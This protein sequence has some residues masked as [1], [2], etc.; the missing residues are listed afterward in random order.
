MSISTGELNNTPLKNA[1]ECDHL[2][3]LPASFV[4][5]AEAVERFARGGGTESA[6]TLLS[7]DL[8]AL[9]LVRLLVEE[10]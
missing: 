3:Q 9:P 10:F 1:Q 4:L 5:P 6:P 2:N 7:F 8:L